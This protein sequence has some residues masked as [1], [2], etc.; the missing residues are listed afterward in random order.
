MVVTTLLAMIV[1]WKIWRWP[2]WA[3]AALMVPFLF[4]DL[5]FFS[6]NMLKVLHGGWV[7]LLIGV[8]SRERFP[9]PW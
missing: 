3:V 7:P 8:L 9:T 5:S 6:A 4:I 2:L 1:V